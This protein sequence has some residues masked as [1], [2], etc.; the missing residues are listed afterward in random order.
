MQ[1]GAGKR[2]GQERYQNPQWVLPVTNHSDQE[3]VL[4]TW[5]HSRLKTMGVHHLGF[6]SFYIEN[7]HHAYVTWMPQASPVKEH[8]LCHILTEVRSVITLRPPTCS[9]GDA[10]TQL[11]QQNPQKVPA[12]I[13]P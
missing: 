2:Q 6:K 9:P 10:A 1:D 13:K 12:P 5:S 3:G 4:I 11:T 8:T 7:V